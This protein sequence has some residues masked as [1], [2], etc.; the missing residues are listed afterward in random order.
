MSI[1]ALTHVA[2]FNDTNRMLVES[3]N[4]EDTV[5][6]AADAARAVRCGF[7]RKEE[8]TWGDGKQERSWEHPKPHSVRNQ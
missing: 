4:F 5:E 3:S 8:G 7:P 2:S 6:I 1:C